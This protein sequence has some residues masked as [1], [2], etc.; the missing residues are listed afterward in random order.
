MIH[1]PRCGA[2][3]PN[4]ARFCSNCGQPLSAQVASPVNRTLPDPNTAFVLEIVLGLFGFLGIGWV[5]AGRVPL[6]LILLVG[7]W[8][9]VASGFGGSLLSG[10]LGFCLWLPVH[11]V[12]PFVSAML[13]KSEVEKATWG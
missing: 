12:A 8:L 3:Q 7:W 6:G 9:V 13:V 4:G 5:Y 10:G 2:Q 11:I 1:C